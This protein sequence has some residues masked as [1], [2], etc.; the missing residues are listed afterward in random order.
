MVLRFDPAWPNDAQTWTM[1]A[2][3]ASDRMAGASFVLGGRLCAAGA[4]FKGASVERY[5]VASNTRTAV[6][7]M[8][9]GRRYFGAVIIGSEGKEQN[10]FDEL[11]A[12][13]AADRR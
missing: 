1:L 3:T 8:I 9:A 12:K 11:L 2:P 10:R 5:D 4:S 7:D 6:A 13:S